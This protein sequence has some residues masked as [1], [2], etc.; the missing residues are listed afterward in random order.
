M[1]FSQ[2]SFLHT[3]RSR[4]YLDTFCQLLGYDHMQL[5]FLSFSVLQEVVLFVSLD[6]NL[7][8]FFA[9]LDS[10]WVSLPVSHLVYCLKAIISVILVLTWFVFH[11][12]ENTVLIWYLLSSDALLLI[13][14][15][16][17]FFSQRRL[18][19]F[20]YSI[21]WSRSCSLPN[22]YMTLYKDTTFRLMIVPVSQIL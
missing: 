22:S 14:S 3:Y 19:V 18:K 10:T 7:C 13:F 9:I 21:S 17:F 5:S 16:F 15:L 4:L 12:S 2:P 20:C 6:S 11:L 8:L 1:V